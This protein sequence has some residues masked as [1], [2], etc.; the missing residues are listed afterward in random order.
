MEHSL[1]KREQAQ[2]VV[3]RLCE[4]AGHVTRDELSKIIGVSKQSI[5][6]RINQGDIPAA[7][8]F[9]VADQFDVSIDWLYRGTGQMRFGD[10]DSEAAASRLSSIASEILS[11][12]EKSDASKELRR[13]VLQTVVQFGKKGSSGVDVLTT[14]KRSIDAMIKA[15]Q[16]LDFSGND[17]ADACLSLLQV[18]LDEVQ[19]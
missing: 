3:R 16:H 11:T 8:Y 9:R 10:V 2:K 13:N 18:A 5:S 7:W 14:A 4:A 17:I 6:N 1:F 12:L 15:M 19:G